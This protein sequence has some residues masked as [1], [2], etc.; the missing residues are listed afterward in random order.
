MALS[1]SPS[2]VTSGQVLCLDAANPRSSLGNR[3]VINWNNWT[4]GSGGTTGYNQNGQ[5]AENQRV[6]D[7]NPW[8]AT[9]TVWEARPLAQTNDDGGWNTD[10]F[11]ID[12]TKMYRYSVWV[13]RTSATAG[14]T[15]YF[16]MYAS[17]AGAVR[18]DNNTVE[19]N[20]YWECTATSNLTQNQWYLWV[21]YVYPFNTTYTGRNQQTG[22]YTTN[23]FVG[24]IGGCNIGTGDLKWSYNS[25]QGIHRTYLYYCPDSTTRLQFYQPRVDLC[26][27]TEPS[28]QALLQNAGSKWVDVSSQGNTGNMYSTV[29]VSTDGGGCFDFATVTGASASAA[30]LGFTFASGMVPTTGSFTFSCWIKNPPT[31]SGQGGLFSNA[32]SADG[33]R[34]GVGLNGCYVLIGGVG[35]VGYSEPTLA[36]SS[37]LSSSLW[38]NV[39]MIFDRSGINSS[40]TPQW[41]LY[42]NGTYQTAT[43]MNASQP[44]FTNA[45]PGIVRA[46]AGTLYTG[47]LAQ[48]SV[49]NRALSA[50]EIA[51]NFNALRGRFG[52]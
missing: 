44:A 9:D 6:S 19:G 38:Y 12:N 30:S 16:G 10:W 32:G 1:H 13:R 37:S 40:G 28:I 45:A 36:F 51:Q 15:F 47:K 39:V 48:F 49:Y 3:S 4:L 29:P 50:T 34:F 25:T 2:S 46:P 43:N 35:G 22:Y 27:G 17:G 52:V 8:G 31:S 18:M 21:G 33:Y 5:T 24:N 14:G 41:Q 20:A 11:N 7:T 26:D 23:G 42:L